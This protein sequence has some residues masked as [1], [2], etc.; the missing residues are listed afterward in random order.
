MEPALLV[1][2][3]GLSNCKCVLF[4]RVGAILARAAIPYPTMHPQPGWAEQ[5]PE[6]WWAAAAQG[7]RR[8]TSEAPE[9]MARVSAVEAAHTA[10]LNCVQVLGVYGY[11][12]EY[13]AQRYMRD[14][15]VLLTGGEPVE[16]IKDSI[17]A[18][19][20]LSSGA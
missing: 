5:D 16:V 19:L 1:I 8:F 2:D 13:D 10:A 15:L 17:G 12:N 18:M 6:D 20:S 7:T 4:S 9:A 14:A 11:A 3:V